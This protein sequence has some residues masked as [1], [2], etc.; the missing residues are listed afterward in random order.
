MRQAD[1]A[2]F[3]KVMNGM[4]SMKRCD[5][6]AESLN[7]WWACFEDWDIDDFK[8]AAAHLLKT[9]TFMPQPN[10]FEAL[11]I[12]GKPT[13]GEV[14]AE[15]GQWLV[16]SPR[17][18]TIRPDAP[19]EIAASIRAMGG[20]DAYAMS[21]VE[22]LPFLERRFCQHYD[23]ITQAG[24]TRAAVEALGLDEPREQLEYDGDAE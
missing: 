12:A 19:R 15:I 11:R 4:A 5:L 21:P 13:A 6:T 2:E 23:Q 7:L 16:Y 1:Q 24:E 9:C 8:A 20:A 22:K 14:F 17:G 18:Y 3:L 10:D